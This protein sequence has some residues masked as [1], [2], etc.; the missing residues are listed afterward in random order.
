[1]FA[2]LASESGYPP[3]R[4]AIHHIWSAIEQWTP[5]PDHR[6]PSERQLGA[7]VEGQSRHRS[8]RYQISGG[9]GAY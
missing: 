4:K 9:P 8:F 3:N 1:M 2:D 6:L 7:A 5:Q